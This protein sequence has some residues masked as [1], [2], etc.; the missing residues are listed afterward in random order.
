MSLTGFNRLRRM[1]QEEAMKPEKVAEEKTEIAVEPQ[2]IEP[3]IK[4]EK[5]EEVEEKSTTAR[6]RGRK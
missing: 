5:I 4:E 6:R 3:E 1:K 2:I